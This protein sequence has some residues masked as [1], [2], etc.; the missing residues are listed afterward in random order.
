MNMRDE[1]SKFVSIFKFFNEN[2]KSNALQV[3]NIKCDFNNENYNNSR[4]YYSQKN[5]NKLIAFNEQP[6]RSTELGGGPNTDSQKPSKP[7]PIEIIH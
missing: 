4:K 7:M 2:S 1:N 6:N 5:L 3:Q